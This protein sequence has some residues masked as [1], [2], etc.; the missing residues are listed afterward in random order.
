[1]ELKLLLEQRYVKRLYLARF[2]SNLGNGISPVA[3]AFGILHLP[4]GSASELGWVL[5]SATITMILMSPFGGVIADKYGRV[6]MVGLCDTWGAIGLLV[7]VGFLQL[8]MFHF[9]CF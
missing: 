4:N 9:G 2:I 1:M 6:R 8:A 3:L 7:Q 5:G